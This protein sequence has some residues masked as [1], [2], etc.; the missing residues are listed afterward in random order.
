ML[1]LIWEKKDVESEGKKRKYPTIH[2]PLS[3]VNQSDI[4]NPT[5]PNQLGFIDPFLGTK[6]WTCHTFSFSFIWR[7]ASLSAYWSFHSPLPLPLPLPLVPPFSFLSPLIFLP[8]VLVSFPLF[9][10][11][12][13]KF[14][15]YLL[16]RDKKKDRNKKI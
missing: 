5:C 3:E 12:I 8:F 15:V 10:F 4:K 9:F 16:G 2:H 1:N 6:K 13:Q 7:F 14:C 11:T